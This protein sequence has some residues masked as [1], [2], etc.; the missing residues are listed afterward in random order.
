[1]NSPCDYWFTRSIHEN[2][3]IKDLMLRTGMTSTSK[4]LKD[5]A[6]PGE[7]KYL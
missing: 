3:V 4:C 1:M 2:L 7:E 5:I 6:M